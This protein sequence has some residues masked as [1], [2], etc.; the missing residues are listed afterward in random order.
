MPLTSEI[1]HRSP[2]SVRLTA[3]PEKDCSPS[4]SSRRIST[5]CADCACYLSAFSPSS[6]DFHLSAPIF[7]ALELTLLC[8][9]RCLGCSNV[10][11]T[12]EDKPTRRGQEAHPPLD[13]AA[14]RAILERIAPYAHSLKI[15]GGEPTLHPQF[16][17]IVAEINRRGIPFT[18][19][20]NA[21]WQNPQEVITLLRAS[22]ACTGL[23]VSLHGAT[24]ASHEAFSS[25]PGSFQETLR[26]VQLAVEA[27]LVVAISTIITHWNYAEVEDIVCL[28]WRLGAEQVVFGRYAGLPLPTIEPTEEQLKHAV[29]EVEQMREAGE[30]IKL[31]NCIPH[32]F[33]PNSSAGC[34]AGIAYCA[35]D[36]WGNM[37]P[38]THDGLLCGNLLEQTVEELWLGNKMK[39]WREFLP[40]PCAGCPAL[41][42]CKGGCQATA[43]QVSGIDPLMRVPLEAP[44]SQ[45]KVTLT[46]YEGLRPKGFYS[47][48]QEDFGFVLVCRDQIAP[49]FPEAQSVVE[50]CKGTLT[51]RQIEESFGTK[52]L[53]LIGSLYRY[54]FIEMV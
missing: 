2:V 26:N 48:L 51:L 16:K 19:F 43:R 39:S 41:D 1:A 6:S 42:N 53:D 17:E 32:C 13:A 25:V 28:A 7:Y 5:Q 24:A 21:R 8:N 40:T 33:I 30:K 15:T 49:L 54:G 18:L 50:V 44:L 14:W 37:R 47:L 35:V 52:A 11:I 36:P 38:C 45:E 22:P 31:G 23:L 46:F 3:S 34:L 29:Q 9:N 12:H 10:F 20:T 4:R 27:G